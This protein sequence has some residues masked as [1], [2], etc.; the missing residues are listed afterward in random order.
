MEHDS[1]LITFKVTRDLKDKLTHLANLKG[2]RKL[3]GLLRDILEE[4][5]ANQSELQESNV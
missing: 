3:S 4:Y 1:V 2:T 5:A